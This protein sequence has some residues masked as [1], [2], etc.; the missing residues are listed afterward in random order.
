MFFF[1]AM[2]VNEKQTTPVQRKFPRHVK[3]A[4]SRLL[5]WLCI[6]LGTLSAGLGLV[7]I[8]IPVLPT[9]VFLL[10][11]ACCYARSS[12]RFY[13]WLLG[14][15]MLGKYLTSYLE[16][17]GVPMK[18]RVLSLSLLWI[19]ILSAVVFFVENIYV[20]LLLVSIAVGISYYI[21]TLPAYKGK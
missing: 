1:A 16:V 4:R 8:F 3:V 2:E 21:L 19:T 10:L 17:R 13:K 6:S 7:G 14:N 12:E 18:T 20:D 9:T 15:R 11:A 5:R